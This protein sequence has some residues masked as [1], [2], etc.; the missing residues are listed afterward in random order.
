MRCSE[1]LRCLP[2]TYSIQLTSRRTEASGQADVDWTVQSGGPRALGS[3]GNCGPRAGWPEPFDLWAGRASLP[4]PL[5]GRECSGTGD[6]GSAKSPLQPKSDGSDQKYTWSRDPRTGASLRSEAP[7][8]V[9]RCCQTPPV[10][11][12]FSRDVGRLKRHSGG[13]SPPH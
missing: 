8:E 6:T 2:G 1:P 5:F 4:A 13:S 9:L 3:A 12:C 7:L 11:T 10:T